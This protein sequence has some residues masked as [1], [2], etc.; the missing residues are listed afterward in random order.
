MVSF[1]LANLRKSV[2]TITEGFKNESRK[3]GRW[4]KLTG[5]LGNRYEEES[6]ARCQRVINE[7][8]G[9]PLLKRKLVNKTWRVDGVRALRWS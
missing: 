8:S 6:T 5:G 4:T 3:K 1:L 2:A 9:Q 7:D